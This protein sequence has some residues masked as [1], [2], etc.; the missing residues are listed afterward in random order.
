MKNLYTLIMAGGSGTR[1]WPRSKVAKPKQYLNIFGD[2]SLL[3]STIKRFSTFTDTENIYIV[4]GKSQAKVLEEQTS[5]LPKNN[6]IYE[7]V[8]KNTLPCI[9]LAAMFAE[10]ENPDGVMVVSPSDHLIKNDELF[11]E[12]VLAAAKIADEK[13]GIVTIGITPTFPATG[14]G[15]VQTAENITGSE[16]IKQFKVERF[17]EKPKEAKANEYL[18]EGGFYWNSG[19]FVFKVSVFLNSVKEFAPDLYSD[20][21][22]IQA[23]FGNASFEQ[24]LDTIYRAVESNSVDYGIMEHA[25]NI[26]LVE[27]NFDW[28]DLGGWE[29]VYL[30]D[31][32]DGNGNAGSGESIFLDTKNSYVYSEKGL[33]A[34]VGMDD[35]IVVQDGDT[36]LVCK[37]ENAEDIKKIVDQLKSEN[38]NQYL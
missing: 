20:L 26:Y 13:D 30:A 18:K 28:N 2:D 25:K 4:S 1:F 38:K 32:K 16:K 5:M 19:L 22:K 29:S 17:V 12:T 3:Q 21:R 23:D 37:R 8:G 15:Y 27:G 7:P 14:Y 31:K 35:V 24:T 11:K 9:G 10:K 34:V 33:V 6:L 36:T